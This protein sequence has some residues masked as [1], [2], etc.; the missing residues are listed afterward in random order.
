MRLWW[1]IAAVLCL[2][3]GSVRAEMMPVP[4]ELQAEIFKRIFSYDKTLSGRLEITVFVVGEAVEKE[5]ILQAFRS[6]GVNS[7]PV[8]TESLSSQS[9]KPQAVYLLPGVEPAA[10]GR[11]CSDNRALSIS[12]VPSLAGDGSVAVSIGTADNRPQIIVNM[13]RLKTEGHE[14]SAQLLKLAKVVQ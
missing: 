6:V 2:S 11:F 13:S 3:T 1:M 9:S 12:G 5:K 8:S 14:L 4:V 10:V 7:L